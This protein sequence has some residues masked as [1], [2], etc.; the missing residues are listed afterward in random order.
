MEG[1]RAE[2]RPPLRT[3]RRRSAG[4]ILSEIHGEEVLERKFPPCSLHGIV[5]RVLRDEEGVAIERVMI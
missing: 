5:E 3:R 1:L 4:E 2:T